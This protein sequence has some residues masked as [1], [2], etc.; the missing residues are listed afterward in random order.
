[1]TLYIFDTDH[2]S[3]YGLKLPTPMERCRQNSVN[4]QGRL[5]LSREFG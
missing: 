2:L 5:D 3:L 4:R 1:M